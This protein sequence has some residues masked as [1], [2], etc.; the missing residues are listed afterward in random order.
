MSLRRWLVAWI[1]LAA[2][3]AAGC[4]GEKIEASELESEIKKDL[5]ADVGI[6]PKAIECPDGIETEKGKR[7]NCTGTAPDG[8]RF[9]IDVVLTDDDGSFEAEVPRNQ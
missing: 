6:A 9:R 7:F 4:G 3:A 2:L 1:G 5:T 8:G